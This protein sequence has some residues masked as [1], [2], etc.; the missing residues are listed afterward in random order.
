MARVSSDRIRD[1][2]RY[3]SLE[4]NY[5]GG[6]FWMSTQPRVRFRYSNPPALGDRSWNTTAGFK[7]NAWAGTKSLFGFGKWGCFTCC[8][9]AQGAGCFKAKTWKDMFGCCG[10]DEPTSQQDEWFCVKTTGPNGTFQ[11]HSHVANTGATC[12]TCGSAKPSGTTTGTQQVVTTPA[13]WYCTNYDHNKS[14]FVAFHGEVPQ[15]KTTCDF[16]GTTKPANAFTEPVPE[17]T[18]F[19]PEPTVIPPTQDPSNPTGTTT[20]GTQGQ[21]TDPDSQ[22]NKKKEEGLKGWHW[23]LIIGG[24]VVIIAAIVGI[25]CACNNSEPEYDNRRY[26]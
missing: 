6:A 17:S 10:T 16:C 20:T 5:N 13:K 24:A 26:G 2:V 11:Q 7:N 4:Y 9:K 21:T 15:S 1:G 23:A 22:T 25:M 19:P 12:A 14:H 18:F 8:G 3:L